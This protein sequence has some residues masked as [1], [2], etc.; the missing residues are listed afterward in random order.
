MPIFELPGS[1]EIS[2]SD[3]APEKI[4]HVQAAIDRLPLQFKNKPNI[5]ALLEILVQPAQELED[6]FWTLAY[7]R[8]LAKAVELGLD[9]IID[10]IGKLVGE[11]R[12]GK[13]NA[14]YARFIQA[15]I[16]ANRS[17]GRVEDLITVTKLVIDDPTA[18]VHVQPTPPAAV[19]VRIDESALEDSVAAILIEFL[20]VTVS[21][22]IRVIL[23]WSAENPGDWFVW[24]TPGSGFDEGLFVDADDG[25]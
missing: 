2:S 22:G 18:Y 1:A 20:K 19:I 14:D 8:T 25:L 9:A 12:G 5:Q 3:V 24:D 16:A 10:L 21:A 13:S 15:R 4:D 11:A 17:H 23:E 7:E 6:V